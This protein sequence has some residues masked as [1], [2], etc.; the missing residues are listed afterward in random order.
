MKV[1]FFNDFSITSDEIQ[2]IRYGN[3]PAEFLRLI[4]NTE[5]RIRKKFDEEGW[6]QEIIRHSPLNLSKTTQNDFIILQD[7]T[8]S[9]GFEGISFA[10]YVD[11]VENLANLF[12]ELVQE[13][14]VQESMGNFFAI[15]SQTD[16]LLHY[17]KHV[18]DRPRPYQ[19]ARALGY[20]VYPLIRTDAMTAA[21]P[22]GHALTA[23]VMGEYYSRLVPEARPRIENLAQKIAMSRE[24]AAIHYPSDTQIS[25]M[26][27]DLIWEHDLIQ[28]PGSEF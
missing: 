5:D 27:S 22:S 10:R 21:Y 25:K 20:E 6:T 24:L 16:S 28:S 18:I 19:L 4:N 26:I 14:G 12:I 17:L 8:Q 11:N 2:S 23:F 9:A 15:D 3:P 7:L 13:Y 1:R